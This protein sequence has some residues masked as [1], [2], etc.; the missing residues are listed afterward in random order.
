MG[1][2]KNTGA[3]WEYYLIYLRKSRKDDPNETVEEVL[4]KHE[5]DLQELALR[6]FG[7]RIPEENIYREIGSSESID[8]RAEMLKVLARIEDPNV[9]GVLVVDPPRLSR[10]DLTDCGR[11]VNDF[12]YTNTLV[13]TPRDSFDLSV[14]RDRRYF[15]DELLR[16]SDYQDYVKDVLQRGRENAVKRGCFIMQNAPYGYDKVKIGKDHTLEPNDNAD[17]VRMIFEWYVNEGISWYK[18]AQRLDEM[19]IPAPKGGKWHKEVLSRMVRN[20][21][22]AGKVVCNSRPTVTVL[23]NGERR[24]RRLKAAPEDVIIAEGK[25]PAIIDPELW[26]RAQEKVRNTPRLGGNKELSNVLAGLL[27]CSCCGYIMDRRP[28]PS[29]ARYFCPTHQGRKQCFKTVKCDV[30]LDALRIA[31]EEAE[32]PALK[33]KVENDEGNARKTQERIIAKLQKQMDEYREQE[34]EQY[35]LLERKKYTQELFDRRNAQLRAKMEE[36]EKQLYLARSAMPKTVNYAEK[37]VALEAAITALHDPEANNTEVN[38]VLKTIIER[39]EFTGSPSQGKHGPRGS[40]EFKL[41]VFL[42]L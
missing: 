30:I 37:V 12:R 20:Q 14:K 17:V 18:M 23:E 38:K 28:L 1:T 10:G 32:L 19:G 2:Y 41:E 42:R 4:S 21:H 3:L 36:C 29:G 33:S 13:I 27:R 6:L 31:L 39:I 8:D 15:Q 22:Y 24:K 9:R 35:E 7:G 11:I 5:R 34:D 16:G 26:D 40:D 25:H